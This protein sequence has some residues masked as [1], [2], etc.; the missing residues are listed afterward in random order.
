M[1]IGFAE[2]LLILGLLLAVAAA[3]SGW[4]H[5]TVLS[6]SVLSVVAG[7]GLALLDVVNANPGAQ[8]VILLVELALILT[9]FS[10]GLLVES[11][12]LREHWGPPARA[13]V[14]AMPVTLVLLAL[15][16]KALFPELTWAEAFL[17]GAVLSPTDPVVTSA[18]VS[19]P[20]VPRLIR[21]TLNLESGLNDGLALPF[22]LFFLV[23]GRRASSPPRRSSARSSASPSRSPPGASSRTS[24]AAA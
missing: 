7:V 5:G 22:V 1:D 9:L 11:E 2:A 19:A 21:H 8:I 16:G 20:R 14:I 4:L 13:L 3:L 10:D 24:R 6:I 23:L 17:L 15:A 18:V 12:L